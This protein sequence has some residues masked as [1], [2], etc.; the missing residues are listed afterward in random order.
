MIKDLNIKPEATKL[1]EGNIRKKFLDTDLGS[2]FMT[3]TPKA[4]ATKAKIS[5]WDNIKLK[6]FFLLL[7]DKRNQQNEKATYGMGE[8][9]CKPHI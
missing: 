7:N 2:D 4:Q 8:N 1:L 6:S 9:I 3:M 5:K